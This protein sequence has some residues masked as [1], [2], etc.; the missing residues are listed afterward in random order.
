VGAEQL[1]GIGIYVF[2]FQ[3]IDNWL[4]GRVPVI[5]AFYIVIVAIGVRLVESDA[6]QQQVCEQ[7]GTALLVG[8]RII[9]AEGAGA[10]G[11]QGVDGGGV[12]GGDFAGD[13]ADPVGALPRNEAFDLSPPNSRPLLVA[14]AAKLPHRP[15]GG[16]WC[17]CRWH[18]VGSAP[19]R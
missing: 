9:G 12:G 16:S 5:V 6:A 18:F 8:A 1:A 19:C 4:Y 10:G 17:G 15:R 7:V 14:H 3:P 13:I 11:E 2:D